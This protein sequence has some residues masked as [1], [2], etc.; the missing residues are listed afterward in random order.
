M[1]PVRPK[2][3]V[4]SCLGKFSTSFTLWYRETPTQ[5]TPRPTAQAKDEP[6]QKSPALWWG[7]SDEYVTASPATDA[8]VRT[9]ARNV[10]SLAKCD[11]MRSNLVTS[12]RRFSIL[13]SSCG[14][15][16]G[17]FN[18]PDGTKGSRRLSRYIGFLCVAALGSSP[19]GA[20]PPRR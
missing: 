6:T 11:D 2:R 9:Q 1:M 10:R 13:V 16:K 8:A 20:T 3:F 14:A 12:G 7:V 5:K 17:P 19:K 4:I 15:A 18:D